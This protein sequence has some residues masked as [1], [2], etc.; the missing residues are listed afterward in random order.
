MSSD[1]ISEENIEKENIRNLK[2]AKLKDK[3]KETEKLLER[4]HILYGERDGAY[5]NVQKDTELFFLFFLQH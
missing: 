2:E 1:N 3:E 4:N 5:I